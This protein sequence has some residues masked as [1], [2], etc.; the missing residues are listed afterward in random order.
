MRGAEAAFN[1]CTSL[2]SSTLLP[3]GLLKIEGWA[4]FGCTSVCFFLRKDEPANPDAVNG[5]IDCFSTI[6]KSLGG[7][8]RFRSSYAALSLAGRPDGGGLPQHS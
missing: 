5:C 4:F 6:V 3:E 7:R 2:L 8:Q 1:G